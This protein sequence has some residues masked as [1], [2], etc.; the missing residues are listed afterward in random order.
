MCIR[1]RE[2]VGGRFGVTTTADV[3]NDDND[4]KLSWTT[5]DYRTQRQQWQSLSIA[6]ATSARQIWA[7]LCS[8]WVQTWH[9]YL[10]A[11]TE[12]RN[13]T[14]LNGHGLVFDELTNM[15]KY[16]SLVIGWRIPVVV[17]YIL[18][19]N[20]LLLGAWIL[21]SSSKTKPGQFRYVVSCA[22]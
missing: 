9:A 7:T 4:N 21:V 6:P 1:D 16:S 10:K 2:G 13:W 20:A 15:G 12:R 14:E 18:C 5:A 19:R 22:F 8:H 3:D 17:D 11:R